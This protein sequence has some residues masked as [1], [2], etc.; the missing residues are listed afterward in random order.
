MSAQCNKRWALVWAL[1]M[2]AHTSLSSP[3]SHCLLLQVSGK[4]LHKWVLQCVDKNS[5]WIQAYTHHR[6]LPHWSEVVGRDHLSVHLNV[7]VLLAIITIAMDT[8][9]V[10]IFVTWLPH[11]QVHNVQ[12][13]FINLLLIMLFYFVSISSKTRFFAIFQPVNIPWQ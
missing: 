6:V 10:D 1:L 3:V 8:S 9:L 2:D 7:C 13:P 4:Q 12:A 5:F 11:S